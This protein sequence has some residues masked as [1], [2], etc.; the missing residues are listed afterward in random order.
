MTPCTTRSPRT[1]T[2]SGVAAFVRA[3][4]RDTLIIQLQTRRFP[5]DSPE[6]QDSDSAPCSE[7]NTPRLHKSSKIDFGVKRRSS[8]QI[9]SREDWKSPK[10]V[11]SW[12]GVP[13]G[14]LSE[15]RACCGQHWER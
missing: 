7:E 3:L 4:N 2:R 10:F 6:N 12:T 13:V 11:R 9:E 14:L 15:H 1:K 8:R 5:P